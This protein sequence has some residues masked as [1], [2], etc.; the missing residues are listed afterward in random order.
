MNILSKS[1][2]SLVTLPTAHRAGRTIVRKNAVP[3]LVAH[4]LRNSCTSPFAVLPSALPGGIPGLGQAHETDSTH[5]RFCLNSCGAL[6]QAT[7]THIISFPIAFPTVTHSAPRFG[8]DTS[9]GIVYSQQCAKVLPFLVVYSLCIRHPPFV[10][11]LL[12]INEIA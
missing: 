2:G 7:N 12:L 3:E 9:G 8:C 4:E 10:A 5:L 1:M 11:F 6:E